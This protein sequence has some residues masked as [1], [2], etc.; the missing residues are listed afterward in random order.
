LVF[1]VHLFSQK[2]TKINHTDA[3]YL[4]KTEIILSRKLS[5]GK[6][7]QI[8]GNI[9]ELPV[10]LENAE[11]LLPKNWKASVISEGDWIKIIYPDNFKVKEE[12]NSK[13]NTITLRA[14]DPVRLKDIINQEIEK[15]KYNSAIEKVRTGIK[16][17]PE[18]GEFWYLG[19]IIRQ[20]LKQ[21]QK[22]QINFAKARKFG[23]KPGEKKAEKIKKKVIPV[24]NTENTASGNGEENVDREESGGINPWPFIL[25][26][27]GLALLLLLLYGQRK[28]VKIDEDDLEEIIGE[29]ERKRKDEEEIVVPE[30]KKTEKPV[31]KKPE[32]PD[33]SVL[34]KKNDVDPDA[35]V[36]YSG[37][38][39]KLTPEELMPEIDFDKD[40]P[41]LKNRD[42][43]NFESDEEI[44]IDSVVRDISHH[45]EHLR[46]E[47]V[48]TDATSEEVALNIA[49]RRL[50]E[51]GNEKCRSVLNML[52]SGITHQEIAIR[53]N[54]S[55]GD[56][57]LVERYLK[58]K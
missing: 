37:D 27:I 3:V 22:A 57:D 18:D 54:I 12:V 34:D 32:K 56:V 23:F 33:F 9:A 53:E 44:A 25:I 15:K 16:V 5:S 14:I 28:H 42:K 26:F 21:P 7:I 49:R 38:V 17:L 46:A 55:V 2:V 24:E 1:S 35:T 11:K 51:L 50:M 6:K 29:K 52:K 30:I 4:D 19:G 8:T 20:K 58:I 41:V 10:K 31:I 45:P 13:R 40:Y 48:D 47:E 39:E 43:D 36:Y